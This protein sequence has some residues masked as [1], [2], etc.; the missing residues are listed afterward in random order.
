MAQETAATGK[1]AHTGGEKPGLYIHV[2]FCKT[3]CP[4]CDFYSITDL[5]AQGAWL[6]ALQVEIDFYKHD[7]GT[8]ETLYIG[9]GTPTVLSER[10]LDNLFRALHAGFSFCAGAEITVEAN[11]DDITKDKLVFLRSRGV[12]RLSVG[13]Q[14]FDENELRFLERRHTA[15]GAEK[16]LSLVREAGFTNFGI[17]LM[18]GLPGQTGEGWLATLRKALTF[19]PPHLSCYELTLEET[20]ALGKMKMAG[21]IAPLTEDEGEK[22]FLRTSRFLQHHGFIH[23]EISNFAR[24]DDYCSRHNRK[25]WRH[26][27]YLGLGPGAHSFQGGIRWWNYRSVDRYCGAAKSGVKPVGGSEILSSEQLRFE[28]LFLGLRTHHG[29]TMEDAFGT[30]PSE[31]LLS[32]I[33]ASGLITMRHNRIVPTLKGFLIADRLP[34]MFPD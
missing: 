15:A 12:N 23:Y 28:R 5:S 33:R 14:S 24:S 1:S 21:Q 18:Y 10:D 19:E 20:T 25:Y 3:K 27:P 22:F 13:V 16:A 30:S 17:D 7:F 29:V 4:Y 2:P 8:F 11:P 26:V 9:G 34:L 6:H 32:R 31:P